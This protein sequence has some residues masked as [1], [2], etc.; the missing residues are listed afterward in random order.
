ML[1]C[2]CREIIDESDVYV[3]IHKAIRRIN[4][5]PKVRYSAR[6]DSDFDKAELGTNGKANETSPGVTDK[7]T[8]SI[9]AVSDIGMATSPKTITFMMRRGSTG[10][11]GGA[12]PG[13][14]PVRAKLDDL[15]QHL[16]HLGPSNPASNPRSRGTAAVTIKS[17]G[18]Q[19]AGG[20]GIPATIGEN[21]DAVVYLD[22][23]P[24]ELDNIYDE[25]TPLLGDG[26]TLERPKLT[27][28]GGVQALRKSYGS[29][30][31][32]EAQFRVAH[33]GSSLSQVPP[34]IRIDTEDAVVRQVAMASSASSAA[35]TSPED[36]QAGGSSNP[37]SPT[38]SGGRET[39][40]YGAT[41]RSRDHTRS[42]SITESVVETGGIRK[43]VIMTS[44]G[45]EEEKKDSDT[46]RMAHV[47]E[48][49]EDDENDE[50][51]AGSSKAGEDLASPSSLPSAGGS[52][53]GS[54]GGKKKSRRKKR[55][56][57]W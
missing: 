10:G 7:R 12:E 30:T 50:Q 14:I 13:P 45:D 3:D 31:S 6:K 8:G 51:A 1:T 16:R 55:K 38:R 37:H 9:S 36:Q 27:G 5:A 2:G 4:P 32:S 52:G 23:P 35:Q 39:S 18:A 17:V 57:R 15:R 53:H 22:I 21:Q 40:S 49:E 19:P 54:S 34:E 26:A 44:S 28:K 33:A 25:E 43:V 41:S 11:G 46:G 42:G 56:Q 48:G 29:L 47:S 20:Q 24:Q